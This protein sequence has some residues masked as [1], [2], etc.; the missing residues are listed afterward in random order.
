MNICELKT[1]QCSKFG[2]SENNYLKAV[3]NLR[4][5]L[6]ILSGLMCVMFSYIMPFSVLPKIPYLSSKCHL[7]ISD[8]HNIVSLLVFPN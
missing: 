6:K 8:H 2:Y 3:T 7:E 5:H 4:M 1:Y